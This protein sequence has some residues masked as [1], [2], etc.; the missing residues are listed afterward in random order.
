[1]D[2]SASVSIFSL[3]VSVTAL[4]GA[5]LLYLARETRDV[6]NRRRPA[7]MAAV[8]W[9]HVRRC[10][11]SRHTITVV[12]AGIAGFLTGGLISALGCYAI[13]RAYASTIPNDDNVVA[14]AASAMLLMGFAGCG[15]LFSFVTAVV[16][17][18]ASGLYVS[19]RLSLRRC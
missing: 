8:A 4:V 18:I 16:S 5:A 2:M 7:A 13:L 9:V 14:G 1:M 10:F 19:K 6:P 15:V 17:G 12:A 11:P 3:A